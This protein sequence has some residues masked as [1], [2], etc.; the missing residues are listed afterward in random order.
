MKTTSFIFTAFFSVL[1]L[2]VSCGKNSPEEVIDGD[3]IVT[4]LISVTDGDGHDLLDKDNPDNVIPD[5]SLV[6]NG[7]VYLV[8]L[9]QQSVSVNPI[10]KIFGLKLM[11]AKKNYLWFGNMD[12]SRSCDYSFKFKYKEIEYPIVLKNKVKS[13]N[14]MERETICFVDGKESTYPIEIVL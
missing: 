10:P 14:K 4:L 6:Y 5:I 3:Y 11:P 9:T 1:F 7:T 13:S 2:F 8:D 12:G